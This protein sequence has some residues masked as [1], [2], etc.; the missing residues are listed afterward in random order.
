MGYRILIAL[1]LALHF[2]FLGYLV[3]GGFVAW[4]WPRTVWLHLAVAGWG[5]LVVAA[6]L[7]CPLTVIEHWAR[8]RAGETGVGQGFIDR[9]IEGVLYPE[10]YA[11]VAQG[12]V[13]VLVVVSWLGLAR[14]LNA[15]RRS[16]RLNATRQ[17]PRLR[18]ARQ[19]RRRRPL[20]WTGRR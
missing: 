7:N 20:R 10:R 3:V 2:G 11:A 4:R 8:R 15:A 19:P 16:P 5:V 12:V 9:Y 13:A 17:P 18:A 14:Q 1:V 6:E